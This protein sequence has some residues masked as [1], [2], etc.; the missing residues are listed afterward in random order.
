[1][2]K[3][4]LVMAALAGGS[5]VVLGAFAAHG[6]K[7][8]LEAGLLSAFGTGVEYQF[9]HALALLGAA[10]LLH[11]QPQSAYWW[12]AA[13]GLFA[14]GILL[15]SGSLYGLALLGWKWLGPVTPLGGL[16]LIAAWLC[17]LIGALRLP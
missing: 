1:M 17:L 11:A 7:G 9:Y 16:C 5:A 4:F 10:L 13:G 15:F 8:R 14:L 12:Q 2:F 6:L 3:L